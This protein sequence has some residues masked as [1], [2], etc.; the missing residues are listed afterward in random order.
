MNHFSLKNT[1]TLKTEFW[2]L[3]L[4]ER[5]FLLRPSCWDYMISALWMISWTWTNNIYSLS[6]KDLILRT[7]TILLFLRSSNPFQSPLSPKIKI[8]YLRATS[9]IVLRWRKTFSLLIIKSKRSSRSSSLTKKRWKSRELM[10]RRLSESRDSLI[11]D[12]CMRCLMSLKVINIWAKLTS[13]KNTLRTNWA[14]YKCLKICTPI[15]ETKIWINSHS[16]SWE[17]KFWTI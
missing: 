17:E 8:M 1:P 10:L 9:W 13:I 4:I 6:G 7:N 15:S 16:L 12:K 2:P 5:W 3:A 14:I 11:S